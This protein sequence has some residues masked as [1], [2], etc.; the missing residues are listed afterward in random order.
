[1]APGRTQVATDLDLQL[2]GGPRAITPENFFP[3]P[4]FSKDAWVL[5]CYLVQTAGNTHQYLPIS[6]W[7]TFLCLHNPL[8]NI[9]EK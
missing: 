8:V 9:A 2:S 7:F 3:Q 1:M 6:T 5:T 4:L